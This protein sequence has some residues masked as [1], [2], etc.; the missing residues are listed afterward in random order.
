MHIALNYHNIALRGDVMHNKNRFEFHV[1][2]DKELP[3]IFHFNRRYKDADLPSYLHWH[4][5]LEI[6]FV[7]NGSGCYISGNRT[8][9]VNEGDIFIVNSNFIHSA[10]SST[11]LNFYCLIPDNE[12]CVSNDINP[13][14]IYFTPVIKDDEAKRLFKNLIS[15]FEYKGEFKNT[16]IRVAVL[17]LLLYL[18]RN[19]STQDETLLKKFSGSEEIKLAIGYIKAH[20]AEKLTLDELCAEAGLSKYYFLR[21]FKT[22]VG[23]TPIEYI[24]LL[25]CNRAKKLLAKSDEDI[26]NIG[27]LC[28]F[29]NFPYFSKTFKALIGQTPSEYRKIKKQ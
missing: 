14:S 8:Y 16:G 23:C 9:D 27:A 7:T 12:F 19:Y 15:S 2:S 21:K 18:A 13:E 25:R 3:F 24:N 22:C 4:P 6:L 20:F 26:K 17:N 1:M 10:Y 28:G 5:N 29:E 11:E